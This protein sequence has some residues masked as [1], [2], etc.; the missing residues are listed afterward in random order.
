MA[1]YGVVGSSTCIVCQQDQ[2]YEASRQADE[3]AQLAR[4]SRQADEVAQ[5]ARAQTS[6]EEPA[7]LEEVTKI[8]LFFFTGTFL[9]VTHFPS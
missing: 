5:L 8:V 1:L 4:A 2:A 9:F 7:S 6:R 3:V